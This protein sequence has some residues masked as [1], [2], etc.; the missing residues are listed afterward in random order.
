MAQEPRAP[1]VNVARGGAADT[2]Q[3]ASA[4]RGHSGESALLPFGFRF[5]GFY[6]LLHKDAM[7]QF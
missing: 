6:P 3:S 4:H 2:A 7:Q 1:G 5:A